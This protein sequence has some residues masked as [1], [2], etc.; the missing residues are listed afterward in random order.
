MRAFPFLTAVG[1]ALVPTVVRGDP[2]HAA[3]KGDAAEVRALLVKDPK[4]VDAVN[5]QAFSI[6]DI[7]ETALHTA[8]RLGQLDVVWLLIAHKADLK[9]RDREGRTPL[10]TAAW[11][12]QREIAELLLRQGAEVDLFSAVALGWTDRVAGLIQGNPDLVHARLAELTPLHWA[13]HFGRAAA[14]DLL[15]RRGAVV[16]AADRAGETPLHLAVR[17]NHLEVARLLL[18]R[19]AD[20]HAVHKWPASYAINLTVFASPPDS[21][22]RQ[23]QKPPRP[24]ANGGQSRTITCL[25][26]AAR[27]GN[28][29]MVRLLLD[30]GADI[31]ARDLGGE[32]PLGWALQAN[33]QAVADL[34]RKRGGEE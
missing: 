32:T 6:A 9:A 12:Q 15:L 29:E 23:A 11:H 20:V 1:L 22:G 8:A 28:A 24:P 13:A 18:A 25:H 17:N 31:N 2:I 10:Q 21:P 33:R 30:H 34:L 3:V 27:N 16:D 7:G 19:K 14:A 4:L 26:E 5:Q